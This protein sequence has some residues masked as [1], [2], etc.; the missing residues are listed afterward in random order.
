MF[1]VEVVLC[2]D[3]LA[4]CWSCCW[5]K[6]VRVLLKCWL[7]ELMD[8]SLTLLPFWS[9]MAWVWAYEESTMLDV[10]RL[11]LSYGREPLLYDEMACGPIDCDD[12]GSS[13]GKLKTPP[14]FYTCYCWT[15]V[16][17][18]LLTFTV[19]G[20]WV[21]LICAVVPPY[22]PGWRCGCCGLCI[23]L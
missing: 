19:L 16:L 11:L 14:C 2:R 3:G 20:T 1:W 5:P 4:P 22:I 17:I 9:L 10:L 23:A 13:S 12:P 6:E 15:I 21:T 8:F 18:F 7:A